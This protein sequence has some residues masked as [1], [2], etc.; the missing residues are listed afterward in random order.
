VV[1]QVLDREGVPVRVG[2]VERGDGGG[3]QPPVHAQRPRLGV[4]PRRGH[5]P[6]GIGAH[7]RQGLLDHEARG[8]AVG[9]LARDDE[10]EVEVAVADLAHRV[11]AG[12][13]VDERGATPDVVGDG[14]DGQQVVF[15]IRHLAHSAE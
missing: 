11:D 1:G 13:P 12:E 6:R 3:A 5:R 15:G 8:I 4:V 7:V 2:V 9:R 14:V 10:D